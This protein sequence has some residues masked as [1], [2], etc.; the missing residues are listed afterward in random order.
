LEKLDYAA[1]VYDAYALTEAAAQDPPRSLGRALRQIGPGLI[2]AGAIVGTGELIATTNLGAKVGFALLWLVI[3]SC[4]VKVFVQ[5]ELGRYTISSGQTTLAGF[6]QLGPIGV[7]F[8]WWWIVMMLLSQLQLGAMIGGIGHALHLAMPGVASRVYPAAPEMP[9]AILVTVVTAAVLAK[10]SYGVV[11][12]LTMLLVVV[13]TAGTVACV[14]LLPA[15]GHAIDWGQVGAG[16]TFSLPPGATTAAVAMFGITGVGAAE[17]IAYPYWC[18]EKGYARKTGPRNDSAEWLDR[19]RGW[20]RVMRLDVWVSLAVYTVATLAFYFLGAATLFGTNPEGL[21]RTVSGMIDALTRM[22][23]PVLGGRGAVLFI[24]AGVIAVLYSTI[25]AASGANARAMVDFLHVNRLRTLRSPADRTRGVRWVCVVLL[26]VD[27][28]LYTAIKDPVKMVITSGFMQAMTLPM[29]A[30]AALYLRYTRTDV[31]LR[32]GK[33][34]DAFLWL[35]SLALLA[36]AIY[37]VWD[38]VGKLSK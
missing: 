2:L 27:L 14:A 10:G 26:F 25:I 37:G 33:V 4:F 19:A 21:P 32:P 16:L 5:A 28:V 23:V 6:R 34:W 3:V 7:L 1:P 35:S 8:G 9:W 31:R 15:T 13:F 11:E 38:N 24:V 30:A 12:S 29:I 17:L 20:L 22:Y 18:I 36:T